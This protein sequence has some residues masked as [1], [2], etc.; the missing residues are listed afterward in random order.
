[1]IEM[2]KVADSKKKT[3]D[4]FVHLMKEYPIIAAVNMENLPAAQLQKMR[5]QLRD[6][7]VI[8]MSKRRIM[9]FAFDKAKDSKPGLEK[10]I[11]HLKGM[12][13]LLFT[14]DN[15]FTLYKILQKNKSSAPAKAGQ[16]APRDLVIPAGPT[17]FA[18][19]PIIGEL[20]ML[21]IKTGVENGKIAVKEDK[22]VAK[23]GEVIKQKVAELLIRFNINP[24]E[25]GLDLTAA[26]ENGTIFD[27]K[28]LHI[29]EK[30][31]EQNITDAAVSAVN[32]AVEIGYP[33]KEIIELMISKAHSDAK[34][35]ALEREILTS[36]TAGNSLAKAEAEMLGLKEAVNLPDFPE[37]A[38]KKTSNSGHSHV[39]DEDKAKADMLIEQ[40]KKNKLD[41]DEPEPSNKEELNAEKYI[42]ELK[43]QDLEEKK[44]QDAL[45]VPSAHELLEKKKHNTQ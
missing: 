2:A 21:G 32:L 36:E 17:A 15:P 33:I 22:I 8:K 40:I 39:V 38:K 19:G 14:K 43:A 16:I 41:L 30:E 37:E 42:D 27:K 44:R 20:G 35:V 4:E 7:V 28:V 34:A 6:T 12:P 10:L 5:A 25:I 31:Y 26:Y 23:E 11:E 9:K 1:M 18:P 24:M 13:A 3:V 29:D 45:R